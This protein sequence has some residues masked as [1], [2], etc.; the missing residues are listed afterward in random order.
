VHKLIWLAGLY[1]LLAGAPLA[2]AEIT[3]SDVYV[4]VL[5]I[6]DEVRL[7]GAHWGIQSN[8]DE[9]P[10][11][12]D[13]KP[14]HAWQKTYEVAVKINVLREKTGLPMLAVN[15]MA[16]VTEIDPGLTYEQTQRILTELRLV[17]A[18][19]GIPATPPPPPA[20]AGKTPQAVYNALDRVSRRLDRIN[21]ETFTPS[22]VFAQAMRVYEDV[23]QLITALDI[24]DATDAPA[25]RPGTTP[26]ETLATALGLLDELARIQ[27]LL[28]IKPTDF[29]ALRVP[30]PRSGDVFNVIQMAIA[31]LQPIKVHYGLR[32]TLTPPAQHYTA[33]TPADVQQV[34]GWVL[35]RLRL[36]KPRGL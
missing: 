34:L 29:S 14:R 33:K 23:Q 25:K 30:Q 10:L 24:Q 20:V 28:G 11:Q 26:A 12:L 5:R 8:L 36:I 32:Y 15:A 21:G 35:D 27:R 22:Y 16:P 1:L 31:E 13:L 17:K 4:Q 18:H 19:L 7:I 6:E 3:P 9:P 2:A